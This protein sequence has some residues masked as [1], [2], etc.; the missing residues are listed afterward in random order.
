M[1]LLFSGT[2]VSFLAG[3]LGLEIK[4]TLHI[5]LPIT[6][7]ELVLTSRQQVP[8]AYCS[9]IYTVFSPISNKYALIEPIHKSHSTELPL[10]IEEILSW[11]VMVI[12]YLH[13]TPTFLLTR[14]HKGAKNVIDHK[15]Y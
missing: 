5:A 12:T 11:V 1:F 8:K 7:H 3:W 13:G 15:T 10:Y 6:A 9:N 14:R 2:Y 4:Y